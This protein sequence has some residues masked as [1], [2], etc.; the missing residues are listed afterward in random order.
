M[1][2][3]HPK[4]ERIGDI[5]D[6]LQ[7]AND[8]LSTALELKERIRK[9]HQRTRRINTLVRLRE[10]VALLRTNILFDQHMPRN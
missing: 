9:I 5:V 4:T 6:S 1:P 7:E 2:E 8:R 10:R 3:P